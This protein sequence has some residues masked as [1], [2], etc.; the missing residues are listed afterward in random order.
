MTHHE[1]SGF[2]VYRG[3]GRP[4][5]ETKERLSVPAAMKSDIDKLRKEMNYEHGTEIVLILSCASDE[6]MRMVHMFPEVFS[7]DVTCST[8]RQNK[9]LFFMVVKDA[10]GE[11]HVGN[12][13]VLPSEKKWVFNEIYKTIFIKLYGEETIKRNRL[14]LTDEDS[15]EYEPVVNAIKTTEAYKKT[16]HMLCVF[17]ALAKKFKE[18]V[19]PTLPH[20]KGGNNLSPLGEK[21]GEN[22]FWQ[23]LSYVLF[24]EHNIFDT[25]ILDSYEIQQK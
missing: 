16:T 6:M 9:P 14:I 4:S 13:S 2:N 15:A 22:V 8:N 5:N 10:N 24:S 19:Y 25:L 18:V 12:I 11:A 21:Y 1:D 7:M 3:K 23:F 17:H 20:M